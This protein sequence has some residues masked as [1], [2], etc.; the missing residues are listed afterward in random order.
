MDIIVGGAYQY[1]PEN[2]RCTVESVSVVSGRIVVKLDDGKV[3]HEVPSHELGEALPV[4]TRAAEP[5]VLDETSEAPEG[6][7]LT[8]PGMFRRRLRGEGD[9]ETP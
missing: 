1:L 2:M 3:V 5:T 4:G 7:G 8:T 9:V 6:Q